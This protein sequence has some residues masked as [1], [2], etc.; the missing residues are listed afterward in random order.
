MSIHTN[1]TQALL[2]PAEAD[3]IAKAIAE[4]YQREV[5]LMECETPFNIDI[6]YK[7]NLGHMDCPTIHM[8]KYGNH[9]DCKWYQTDIIC[10]ECYITGT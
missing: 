6:E 5:S 2:P 9:G 10:L 8:D 4:K 7:C 1:W 3:S